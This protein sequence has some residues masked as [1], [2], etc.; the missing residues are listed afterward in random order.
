MKKIYIP[1]LLLSLM[2]FAFSGCTKKG[3]SDC[4]DKTTDNRTVQPADFFTHPAD[5]YWGVVSGVRYY[6]NNFT[7]GNICVHNNPKVQYFLD[8]RYSNAGAIH[9]IAV[10]AG[11]NTCYPFQAQEAT[12]VPNADQT[13]YTCAQLSEIGMDQCYGDKPSATI[14]PFIRLSFNTLGSSY[15]D[16]IFLLD[17]VKDLQVFVNFNKLK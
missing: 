15:D 12:M 4:G 6:T 2:V 14:Y 17:N 7:F 11:T 8:L 5:I 1:F 9:P 13:T 16:S 10:T 3:V